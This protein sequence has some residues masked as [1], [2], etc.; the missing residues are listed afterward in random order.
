M[1]SPPS[2]PIVFATI[3]S[4]GSIVVVATIL[5]TT[6]FLIGSVPSARI[7]LIC[8]VTTI[9]PSSDAI[10]EPTRARQHQGRQAPAPVREPG[11]SATS[12]PVN[13]LAPKVDSDFALCNVRTEPVK[14]PVSIT[15]D[16]RSDADLVHLLQNIADSRTDAE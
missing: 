3:V 5:G 15:T 7:A 1:N 9:E 13:P 16:N 12:R 10:P 14:N 4:R 6:S 8:S 11:K 2:N